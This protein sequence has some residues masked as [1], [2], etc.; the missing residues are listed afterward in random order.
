MYASIMQ[1]F[2]MILL[3]RERSKEQLVLAIYM[4][5]KLHKIG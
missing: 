3:H 4:N 5:I 2:L 1:T